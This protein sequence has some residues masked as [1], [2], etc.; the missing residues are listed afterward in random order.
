M[1]TIGILTFPD[2][3]ELDF[4]GPY[5]VF[6][7]VAALREGDRVLLLGESVEPVRCAKGML[8]VPHLR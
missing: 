3:E 6:A 2:A 5:E 4:V 1:S 7:A 8:V